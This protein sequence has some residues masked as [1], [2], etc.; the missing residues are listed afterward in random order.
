MTTGDRTICCLSY[1][2]RF[3]EIHLYGPAARADLCAGV[4]DY[5]RGVCP[6]F[7]VAVPSRRDRETP[8]FAQCFGGP[9]DGNVVSAPQILVGSI[10]VRPELVLSTPTAPSR[11][12][13]YRWHE[14]NF[15]YDAPATNWLRHA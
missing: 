5:S 6:Q 3:V 15:R 1:H 4:T 11:P 14:D 8:S 7:D 9:F 12:S 10:A 2:D 13:I